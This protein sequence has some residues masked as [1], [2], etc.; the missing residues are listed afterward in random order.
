[1]ITTSPP[2]VVGI[3][4][5]PTHAA[6]AVRALRQ[7]GFSREDLG[8]AAREWHEPFQEVRVDLQEASERGAKT[9]AITGGALGVVAGIA[10]AALLPVGAPIFLGVLG[11]V[12]AG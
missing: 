11:P 8:L 4:K 12:L 10:G 2:T 6:A 7:A 9:G 1:M 5:D 3:F